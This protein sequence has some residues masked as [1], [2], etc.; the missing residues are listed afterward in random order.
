MSGGAIVVDVGVIFGDDVGVVVGGDVV[1]VGV[2]FFCGGFVYVFVVGGFGFFF[3]V[4]VCLWI[5]GFG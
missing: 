1:V 3:V 4:F 2:V 5:L